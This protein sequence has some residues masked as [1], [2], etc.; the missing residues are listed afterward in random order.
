MRPDVARHGF[1]LHLLWLAVAGVARGLPPLAPLTGS[2]ELVSLGYCSNARTQFRT[3]IAPTAG[4]RLALLAERTP[5]A[6]L[7]PRADLIDRRV[8]NAQSCR[9]AG[10]AHAHIHAL[11]GIFHRG[12]MAVVIDCVNSLLGE[13]NADSARVPAAVS[14]CGC[15]AIFA[16]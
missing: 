11:L 1:Y 16:K 15:L 3:G 8:A 5:A 10:V 9:I 14:S 2:P 6:Q 13:P 12:L 7:S 4:N